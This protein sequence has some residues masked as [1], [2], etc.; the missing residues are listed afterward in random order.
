MFYVY[1]LYSKA[2]S[3]FYIG[4]SENPEKRLVSHNSGISRYTSVANDWTIVHTESFEDRTGAIKR[5]RQ[6]KRMKSRRYI[7]DLVGRS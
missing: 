3:R 6:I 5:E 2:I 1:I 4:Q 7:E